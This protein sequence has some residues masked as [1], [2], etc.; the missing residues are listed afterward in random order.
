M[1]LARSQNVLLVRG[2]HVK[3]RVARSGN[4]FVEDLRPPG[5]DLSNVR[6]GHRFHLPAHTYSPVQFLHLC[7]LSLC[8]A[9]VPMSASTAFWIRPSPSSARRLASATVSLER[10]S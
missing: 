2:Q 10:A 5:R 6:V 4:G 9:R 3:G 1:C 7:L 8:L